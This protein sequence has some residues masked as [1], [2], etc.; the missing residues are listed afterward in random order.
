M[1]N[2]CYNEIFWEEENMSNKA[3]DI[4]ESEDS[5]AEQATPIFTKDNGT[6]KNKPKKEGGI[7]KLIDNAYIISILGACVSIIPQIGIPLDLAAI[8]CGA[9]AMKRHPHDRSAKFAVIIG[10]KFFAASIGWLIGILVMVW[11]L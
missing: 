6:L 5:I 11:E 8:I 3:K 4:S 2:H 7:Y 1:K 9:I 10:S